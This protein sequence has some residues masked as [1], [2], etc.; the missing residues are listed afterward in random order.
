MM[1]RFFKP[2]AFIVFF[3]I[4]GCGAALH[5]AVI[6]DAGE[7]WGQDG[8]HV[9]VEGTVAMEIWQHMIAPSPTYPHATYFDA[10]KQQIVIYSKDAIA[11]TGAV[12]VEGTVVKI[13]GSSKDPRRKET[14]TE[15]HIMVDA[16]KCLN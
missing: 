8:K 10:G 11:C 1:Y 14:C 13:E 7:L 6:R 16:W 4:A 15:Y 2:I 9:V 5:H 12:Q 3:L